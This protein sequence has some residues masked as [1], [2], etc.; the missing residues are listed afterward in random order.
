MS[1]QKYTPGEFWKRGPIEEHDLGGGLLRCTVVIYDSRHNQPKWSGK[2]LHP[3]IAE[4]HWHPDS[5]T[6]DA[7]RAIQ[8][9]RACDG[10][11]PEAVK[12][13]LA[14]KPL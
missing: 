2:H 8:C 1:E 14:E 5:A 13:M 4:F 10:T 6:A 11:N 9:I 7:D 3:V 12:P